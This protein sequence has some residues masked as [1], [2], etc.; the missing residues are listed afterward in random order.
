VDENPW[1]ADMS[2]ISLALIDDHPLMLAGLRELFTAKEDFTVA[3]TGMNVDEALHIS[4]NSDLDVIIVDLMMPGNIFEAIATI[5]ATDRRIK[6]LVFTAMT[7]SDYAV[8]ALNAG[9]SGYILKGSGAEELIQA[10]KAVHRG[11]TFISPG[12]AC[13]VIEELKIASLRKIAGGAVKLSIREGQIIGMLLR[14]FTNRQIAVD[15]QIGEKTVKN[16]MTILM[17]KLN[18]RNRLE[19]LIAAQKLDGENYREHEPVSRH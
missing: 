9:A 6:I 15:L 13:K 1:G 10:V 5:V 16:Y 14:G 19:V 7:R 17:Q 4:I 12:F 11:E 3:A 2:S 18:A 8:R